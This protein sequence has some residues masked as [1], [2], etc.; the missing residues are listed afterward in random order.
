MGLG[1][2]EGADLLSESPVVGARREASLC[3]LSEDSVRSHG[4]LDLG[5]DGL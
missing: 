4:G 1:W 3:P 5:E 2:G